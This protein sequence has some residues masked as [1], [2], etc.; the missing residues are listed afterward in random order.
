M[1]RACCIISSPRCHASRSELV[2]MDL[3]DS[4]RAGSSSACRLAGILAPFFLPACASAAVPLAT[5]GRF[6]E[7]RPRERDADAAAG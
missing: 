2:N 3:N 5:A 4:A 1:P 6:S 7:F